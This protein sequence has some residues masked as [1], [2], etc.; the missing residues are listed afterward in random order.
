MTIVVDRKA[1]LL[2]AA[3]VALGAASG[4]LYSQQLTMTATY[5]IPAGVYNQIV[6]TG[7]SGATPADTTLNRNAGNTILVPPTNASGM[8]GIGTTI[9]V[10]PLEV[11]GSIKSS[12]QASITHSLPGDRTGV[13]LGNNG[14]DHPKLEF[15]V[16]DDSWRF[17]FGVND[18]QL[19]SERLS[20]YAGPLNNNA[21]QEAVVFGGN[22]NVGVGTNAPASR[23]SVAGGVQLG[24]DTAACTASKAGTLRWNSSSGAAEVCDGAAWGSLGGA[25]SGTQGGDCPG[26]TPVFP[27]TACFC[28][29]GVY[30]FIC[31]PTACAP[32]WVLNMQTYENGGY[33]AHLNR[34]YKR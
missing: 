16:S 29:G 26:W 32:G 5:P 11:T 14:N 2:L 22:G 3:L 31:E 13:T 19:P 28:W 9:P 34:C 18:V 10:Y 20:L 8:V 15:N 4:V 12:R 33:G 25:V 7:N 17:W 30:T 21:T 24:D 1:C 6:T 27:A 23:L